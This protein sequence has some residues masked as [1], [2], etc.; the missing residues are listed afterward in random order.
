MQRI[1]VYKRL[2]CILLMLL[3]AVYPLASLAEMPEST[4]SPYAAKYDPEHPEELE[5]DQLAAVS[6][7]LIERSTGNVVF[8]KNADAILY[9]ASTTKI[10]TVYLGLLTGDLRDTVKISYNGSKAYACTV[11]DPQSSVLGLV[12]GEEILLEDLLYG[13]ML[14]SGN[15]AAIAI[16]EYVSG[17]ESAFVAYMN[18][19]A[20]SFGMTNTRFMN[21]H[22]LHDD[23]HYTTARDLATLSRLAM[24][25][26]TFEKIAGSV[27]HNMPAT[28][29]NREKTI[30]TG[31]RIMLK[32]YDGEANSYYYAPITGI[33][34]G[35][36][37]MA[38]NC[39][40]GAAEKDGVELISVVLHSN[41]YDVWRDTK[42]LFEYGF[43]Q[44]THVT[45]QEL[46]L[47]NPLMVY[48]SGYDAS[49]T[50]LGELELSCS[51]VDPTRS[52]SITA[53]QE[54]IDALSDRLR[55]LVLVQYTRELRAPIAAGEV[56][57]TM[58]YMD[59]A[60]ETYEYNLLATR[61]VPARQ[62]PPLTLEQIVAKSEA[63]DSPLPPITVEVV[64][65]LLSPLLAAAVIILI[66]RLLVRRVKKHYA[67]LPRNRNRY[68][69]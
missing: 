25:D 22:G 51:P 12:E 58:I 3:F 4:V 30:S 15:D 44:Y 47:E 66:L 21:S 39:Y 24:E 10:M 14:R 23:N 1:T 52:A 20:Q 37:S 9:P 53:T 69:K 67:R 42:K 28:N 2:T 11:L 32:T 13:C 34:S 55:D 16:A 57:G 35:T 49:D 27:T 40:V 38:G 6:A 64:L 17:S 65:I 48:T 5:E 19:A 31:H 56:I 60:G 45:F 41:R 46:Y 36:T 8:E 62:N 63:D 26:A 61:S 68:V 50:R 59:N 29:E 43:S 33:K 18:Q 7:I 54:E